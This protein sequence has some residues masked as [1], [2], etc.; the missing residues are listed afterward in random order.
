VQACWS[1]HDAVHQ[2]R[3][4][5]HESVF[6]WRICFDGCYELVKLLLTMLEQTSFTALC[7]DVADHVCLC[8]Q[9]IAGN[10]IHITKAVEQFGHL[11]T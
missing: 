3:P 8:H 11:V 5:L 7:T 9:H 2:P 10:N 4:G 6:R 1:L